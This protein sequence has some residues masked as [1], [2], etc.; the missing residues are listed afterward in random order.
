MAGGRLGAPP[1]LQGP[2]SEPIEN[3]PSG[4]LLRARPRSAVSGD[5]DHTT[6][7]VSSPVAIAIGPTA[8]GG[9]TGS[10][11]SRPRSSETVFGSVRAA[12]ILLDEPAWSRPSETQPR[13]KR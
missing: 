13:A 10:P 8:Q 9:S 6:M 4:F 7:W 12:R 1:A 2:V 5:V 11:G 3:E